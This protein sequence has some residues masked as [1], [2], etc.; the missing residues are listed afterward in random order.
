M[1]QVTEHMLMCFRSRDPAVSLDL[2][3]LGLVAGIEDAASNN[4]KDAA[5]DVAARFQCQPEDA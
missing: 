4:I 5:K 1:E 2:M 3:M